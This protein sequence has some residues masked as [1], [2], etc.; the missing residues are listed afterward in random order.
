MKDYSWLQLNQ[1][2]KYF[3]NK[4]TII[5]IIL[6]SNPSFDVF[7]SCANSVQFVTNIFVSSPSASKYML[8]EDPDVFKSNAFLVY[9][10]SW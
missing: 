3:G 6:T 1:L 9:F 2:E 4:Y 7:F 10:C 5:L 8:L